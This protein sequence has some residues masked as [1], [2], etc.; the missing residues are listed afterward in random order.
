M[1]EA[2][3]DTER[4]ANETGEE[5]S[6]RY[7]DREANETGEEERGR[8]PDREVNE[9]GE[10]ER[11]RDPDR[12]VNERGEE[13]SGRYTNKEV[14]E[15]GEEES[16]RDE[17]GTN[18]EETS[19]KASRWP[20]VPAGVVTFFGRFRKKAD[21]QSPAALLELNH[22]YHGNR[23]SDPETK[24]TERY[25][26]T[27][28]PST[29]HDEE[30]PHET[31]LGAWNVSNDGSSV[32]AEFRPPGGISQAP[33]TTPATLI[34]TATPVDIPRAEPV[35]QVEEPERHETQPDHDT[36]RSSCWFAFKVSC[37]VAGL[38]AL[39]GV[40]LVLIVVFSGTKSEY[41]KSP[42]KIDW[43]RLSNRERHM[44]SLLSPEMNG[45]IDLPSYNMPTTEVKS[46]QT[47]AFN[48]TMHDPSFDKYRSWRLLQRYA[49]ACL[50]FSTG[51]DSTWLRNDGWLDYD[52]HE[53]D[54]FRVDLFEHY[55]PWFPEEGVEM[56]LG[57]LKRVGGIDAM[58]RG[59][60]EALQHLWLLGNGLEGTIP[61][62]LFLLT[63][64]RS[65]Q[66]S[67]NAFSGSFPSEIGYLS[68][69]QI[70]AV[71][72]TTLTG[73]PTELGL[74]KKLVVFYAE[75]NTFGASI[76]SEIM[77]IPLFW[78]GLRNAGIVGTIPTEIGLSTM[79]IAVYLDGNNISLTL[80]SEIGNLGS[81]MYFDAR[82]NRISGSIPT[83][84]G[85][86]LE[87]SP[88]YIKLDVVLFCLT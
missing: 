54:W 29:E 55:K 37:S 63:S 62:E 82:D 14:N 13:E 66:L 88:R 11:G 49:L 17:G 5:E 77:E 21:S 53:D 32:N 83:E 27:E 64:L 9:R 7:N 20:R 36:N 68:D 24:P 78:L 18:Q 76:P 80:P 71:A 30:T 43:G 12:E 85:L 1:K 25:D 58:L 26:S 4:E 51:G 3:R 69:L 84:M 15:T 42:A 38:I 45:R 70:L 44:L 56:A 10:E 48:W 75:D 60:S 47:R 81:L 39:S 52:T 73:L 28:C 74:L 72:N 8:D 79:L 67:N 57:I 50:Y 33:I 41:P 65:V 22:L 19:T 16:G 31:P 86:I 2:D 87:V 46:P 35:T 6:G 34:P 61:P 40:L 59:D 23:S